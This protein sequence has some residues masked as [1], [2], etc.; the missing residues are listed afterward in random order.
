M[1]DDFMDTQSIAYTLL[2][3]AIVKDKLSHAYLINANQYDKAFDF[4]LAFVKAIVCPNHYTNY[5]SSLCLDCSLCRRIENHNYSEVKVIE[6]DSLT[7]KKE[8]LLELQSEFSLSGVE[9]SYR[10]YI[11]KDCDKMN[12]QAANCLLKFLEE[13][14]AGVVAILL[15]NHFNNILSTI[16]SRCQVIHLTNMIALKDNSSLEN[17][18][19]LCRDNVEEINLFQEDES[20]SE[21]IECVLSFIR[22][23][24]ENGLDILVFMKN[25]WYNKIQTRENALLAFV[26]FVQFYYDV[27]KCK[28]GIGH[29]F[30]CDSVDDIQNISSL[31]SVD[32]IL[33][34]IAV[35]NYGYDMIKCNLNI[36]LL[37]DDIVIRLGERNECC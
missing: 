31:N 29:Y 13:P 5:S 11:I 27:L 24:E 14:V 22:Y 9:G 36:N 1:L 32:S 21:I 8:Q 19:F 35:F 28:L 26:L 34:K 20:N 3:N 7:I 4:V 33:Y 17:L 12:K 15:T 37:M 18:A 16:I 10:I 23:F 25:I 2:K 30:F 6:T